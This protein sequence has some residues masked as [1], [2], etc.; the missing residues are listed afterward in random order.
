MNMIIRTKKPNASG[1][2]KQRNPNDY[3]EY[4]YEYAPA[5][6]RFIRVKKSD[7]IYNL[8]VDVRKQNKKEGG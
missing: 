8:E 1:D 7:Y 4:I 3:N 5:L 2:P 6:K